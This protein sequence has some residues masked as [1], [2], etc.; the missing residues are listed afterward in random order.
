MEERSADRVD[1]QHSHLSSC[2]KPA[3]KNAVTAQAPDRCGRLYS[4]IPV[5]VRPALFLT[6][7]AVSRTGALWRLDA[8]FASWQQCL[9]LARWTAN[10]WGHE[11]PVVGLVASRG[12][13]SGPY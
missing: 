3:S 6:E 5:V 1:G 10:N 12:E 13:K 8:C 9:E 11:S 4:R 7:W 2:H